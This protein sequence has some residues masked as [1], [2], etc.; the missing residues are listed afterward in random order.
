M[1]Q[2]PTAT[3]KNNII[4]QKDEQMGQIPY[5]ERAERKL[6]S[7]N[8]RINEVQNENNVHSEKSISLKH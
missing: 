3:S 1:V 4:R 8:S 5:P 2:T 7:A 6:K